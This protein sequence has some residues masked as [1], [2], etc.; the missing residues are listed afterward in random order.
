MKNGIFV[1]LIGIFAIW[2]SNFYENDTASEGIVSSAHVED[3]VADKSLKSNSGYKAHEENTKSITSNAKKL[4]HSDEIPLNKESAITSLK[5]VEE[6]PDKSFS[7]KEFRYKEE[8]DIRRQRAKALIKSASEKNWEQFLDLAEEAMNE[9]SY[10]KHSTLTSAIADKAP[11]FVFEK[12]LSQGAV[13]TAPHLMR[14]VS[15]DDLDFLK[16]LISLGL[17]IHMSTFSGQNAI[18][19]LSRTL[20]SRKNFIFLLDNNVSIKLDKNGTSPLTQALSRLASRQEALFYIQK[21]ISHG[22]SISKEDIQLV[23]EAKKGNKEI[24]SLIKAYTP[25]LIED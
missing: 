25:E 17:D 9:S 15:M 7:N 20:A 24:Y 8:R 18:H 16:L 1:L 11:R 12:L 3:I 6:T 21:L 23:K 10:A 13:F 2:Y 14:V 5:S 22:A 4:P 19:S